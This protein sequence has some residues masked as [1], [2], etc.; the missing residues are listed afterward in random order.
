MSAVAELE[1]PQSHSLDA[2]PIVPMTLVDR[3]LLEQQ[4]LT[5]VE[6]FVQR[7]E[8][9]EL[10]L[11]ARYYTSLLPAEPPGPDEQY[12]FEVDLDACSGCKACVTACN[13]LNGLDESETWRE[14]GL[15]YGGSDEQPF[16]QHV[17]AACH[18]CLDP[19]CLN[20]CPVRAYEKSE[21]TGIVRHLDDQCIGCQ[22]CILAC[23]YD[24]PKYNRARGIVRKCDMCSNRLAIGEAPACVQSCP[25][26]AIRITTVSRQEAAENCE[27]GAF[28]SGAPDPQH[29]QPTTHYKTNRVFP[30]NT[31]P[32]DYYSFRPEHAHWPLVLMLVLTQLSVG[33]FL[34]EL[35]LENFLGNPALRGIRSV[36]AGGALLFGLVAL[37]ASTLHLGRPHLAFR[38]VIG[39]RTSWL[40]REIFAF[41]LFAFLAILYSGSVWLSEPVAPATATIQKVLGLGVVGTGFL[42]I[43]CSIMI[44]QCTR[45]ALW[46][47]TG[48]SVRFL[49]TTLVLGLS[50]ALFTTL[51]G[52]DCTAPGAAD[53]VVGGYAELL[54]PALVIAAVLKLLFEASLFVH[55]RSKQNTPLKRSALLLTGDLAGAAK[56][57]FALGIAGGILLPALWLWL[58]RGSADGLFLHVVIVGQFAML[59]GGELLERYLFFTAVVASRM[60]GGLR[61]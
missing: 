50:T 61:T 20:V 15:L 4:E 36:H 38:A 37:A 18:H 16:L 51:V 54:F 2:H 44:Y 11:Q 14:V 21:T 22:Y 59:L 32:A 12:A 27:T 19:A 34:I 47:G 6:Q 40:S 42:G 45:R 8:T 25:N 55:L 1:P 57:R 29:T 33:A 35:L 48:T 10:P 26:G 31:L 7:H 52:A 46:N 43:V 49:L 13:S 23:P 3:Y 5:A 30:R 39:L 53:S 58:I 56:W 60:P 17:T 28:L 41:G 24:V 9:R